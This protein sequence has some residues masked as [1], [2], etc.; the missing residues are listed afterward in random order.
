MHENKVLTQLEPDLPSL[1]MLYLETSSLQAGRKCSGP[2]SPVAALNPLLLFENVP[3]QEKK[4][5]TALKLLMPSE[6]EVSHGTR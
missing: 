1:N 6:N 3:F 5:L 2:H 4:V